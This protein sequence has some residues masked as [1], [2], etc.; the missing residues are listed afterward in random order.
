MNIEGKCVC[1]GE[2]D[3]IEVKILIILKILN[4]VYKSKNEKVLQLWSKEDGHTF[5]NKIMSHQNFQK[6]YVSM[7]QMQTKQ[8]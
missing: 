3:D 8:P 7:M 1:K 6:Y 4:Y 5:F 2:I